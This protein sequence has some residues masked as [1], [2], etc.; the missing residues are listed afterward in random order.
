MLYPISQNPRIRLTCDDRL[1]GEGGDPGPDPGQQRLAP[2][3]AEDGVDLQYVIRRS[4]R[5]AGGCLA[6]DRPSA[7]G[8]A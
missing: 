8:A 7:R 5:A 1:V 3:G 6:D 4:Y 2:A